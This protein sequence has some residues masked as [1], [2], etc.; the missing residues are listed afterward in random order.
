MVGVRATLGY[1]FATASGDLSLAAIRRR[2]D[3]RMPA[4]TSPRQ[5]IRV[6]TDPPYYDNIGYADLSDFFYVWLRRSIGA[7]Y[8][9]LTATVLTP[10]AEELVATPHRFG[11]ASQG[12]GSTSSVVS[13]APSPASA[14]ITPR[15]PADHLL[16]LQA[17]RVRHGGTASTGW[18]TMLNG[19]MEAGLT[20]TAT[21][22]MRT[23][24]S[25]RT[26]GIGSN[27]RLVGRPRLPPAARARRGDHPARLPL[28][29]SK[30][31]CRGLARA[32]TGEHCP[33]RSRAGGDRARDG[34]FTAYSKVV[35]ADGR[36]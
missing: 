15:H 7:V 34:G 1:R 30:T 28:P 4:T 18:E 27:A 36:R 25:G 31:G 24:R 11:A 9:D 20:V 8:P 29:P 2:G 10:K 3:G 26:I 19:L 5:R 22:P 17:G 12:R 23:E 33:G 16:R 14:S 6:P 13:S 21:W 32:P 35:E